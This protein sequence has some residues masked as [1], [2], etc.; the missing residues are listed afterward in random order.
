MIPSSASRSIEHPVADARRRP[1]VAARARLH[2]QPFGPC[3]PHGGDDLGLGLGLDNQL[4][5]ALGLLRVVPAAAELLVARRAAA[6]DARVER[7]S[8]HVQRAPSAVSRSSYETPRGP[9][10]ARKSAARAI[11][12]MSTAPSGGI[13][14]A[15]RRGADFGESIGASTASRHAWIPL[16]PELLRGRIASSRA[17]HGAPPTRGPEPGAGWREVAFVTWTS[18]PPPCARSARAPCERKRNAWRATSAAQRLEVPRGCVG[19][20][21]AAPGVAGPHARDRDGVD[22]GVEPA[23]GLGRLRERALEL[24]RGRTSARIAWAPRLRTASSVSSLCAIAAQDQPSERARSRIAP[25]RFLAPSVTSAG[26]RSSPRGRRD[27]VSRG[28]VEH[29]LGFYFKSAR[30]ETGWRTT[31]PGRRCSITRACR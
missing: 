25:P 4:R 9:W 21:A 11:S 22:D 20:R 23:Q 16:R 28:T 29:E 12:A 24:V 19:Y 30:R 7:H 13:P 26:I 17:S 5:V 8:G 1:A 31:R 14:S 10:P 6:E 18:V 3:Q 15:A 27:R 2:L